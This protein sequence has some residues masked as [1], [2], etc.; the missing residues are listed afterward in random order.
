MLRLQVYYVAK[1]CSQR[2]SA[3]EYAIALGK[4]FVS[5]YAEVGQQ[6]AI[7]VIALRVDEHV[8]TCLLLLAYSMVQARDRGCAARR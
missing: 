3:E 4:H 8:G 6:P 2:C 1:Q 5:T 7:T